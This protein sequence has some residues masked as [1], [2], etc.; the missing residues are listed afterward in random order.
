MQDLETALGYR[1]RKPELLEQ[2]LTH[3]SCNLNRKEARLVDY[4]RL[5]FLGD[6]ILGAVI[7]DLLYIRHPEEPEGKLARRKS[8]LVSGETLS[9][10]AS[11]LQLGK[12][13]RLSG[14]EELSGGRTRHSIAEDILEAIIGAMYLDGGFDA[15]QY[16]ITAQWRDL[17]DNMEAAPKDAKTRLQEWAQGRGLPLPD[18]VE[19][20]KSGPAHSPHFVVE[21]TVQGYPPQRG[22]AASKRKAEQEAAQAFLIEHDHD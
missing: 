20:I 3:P 16:F 13:V 14:A 19:V 5:E 21:V 6:S 11:R 2:A 10:I 7:S 4:Q 17:V 15:A 18:Y 1:F 8:A 22:E 12:Y 9:I